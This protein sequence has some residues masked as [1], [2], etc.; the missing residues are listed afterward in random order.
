MDRNNLLRT[1]RAAA[2]SWEP[3]I[4]AAVTVSRHAWGDVRLA[5]V[6]RMG[7]PFSLS[8]LLARGHVNQGQWVLR[9]DFC[10]VAV[11]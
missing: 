9:S 8:T 2:S 1:M 11:R 7:A 10:S 3:E 6:G 5:T 4:S